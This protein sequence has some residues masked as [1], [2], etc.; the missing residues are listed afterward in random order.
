VGEAPKIV[1]ANVVCERIRKSGCG[2]FAAGDRGRLDLTRRFAKVQRKRIMK[3][4]TRVAQANPT[5][6][7]RDFRSS[8]KMTPRK[9]HP[10][11]AIP[12]ALPLQRLKKWPMAAKEGVKRRAVSIPPM[13]PNIMI[14]CQCSAE[15][16]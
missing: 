11:A 3:P 8:V 2:D 5:V 13:T 9:A 14:K 6:G 4:I 15:I 12:V 16:N 7:I 10:V 1:R